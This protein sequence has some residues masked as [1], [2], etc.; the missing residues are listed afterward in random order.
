MSWKDRDNNCHAVAGMLSGTLLTFGS[1]TVI[2]SSGLCGGNMALV[3]SGAG[4]YVSCY[5]HTN[6]NA[7]CRVLSVAGITITQ[8]DISMIIG[9]NKDMCD[10]SMIPGTSNFVATYQSTQSGEYEFGVAR[11]GTISDASIITFGQAIMFNAGLTGFISSSIDAT[12]SKLLVTYS[13]K[14]NNHYGT[15]RVGIISGT[16][17]S[18]GITIHDKLY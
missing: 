1:E 13:D 3:N 4:Q 7:Y 6:T 11:I 12:T 5:Q 17:I 8:G 18:F 10:I 15:A 2:I 16:S 9:V 14:S